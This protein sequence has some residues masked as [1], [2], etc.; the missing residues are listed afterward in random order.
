MFSPYSFPTISLLLPVSQNTLKACFPLTSC[1]NSPQITLGWIV[2]HTF[3]TPML[4]PRASIC[5]VYGES[6]C[7]FHFWFCFGF[8]LCSWH[9]H[10][11]LLSG[12]HNSFLLSDLIINPVQKSLQNPCLHQPQFFQF[13]FILK[14]RTGTRLWFA[15]ACLPVCYIRLLWDHAFMIHSASFLLTSIHSWWTNKIKY[16]SFKP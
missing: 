4:G 14:D 6:L 3:F 5:L 12:K 7:S 2:S 11:R 13:S 16:H 1:L 9:K 10:Y 8:L 15:A